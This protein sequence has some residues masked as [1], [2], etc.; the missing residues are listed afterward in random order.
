[1]G[2]PA[3]AQAWHEEMHQHA[4]DAA[5]EAIKDYQQSLV[6]DQ[7]KKT[8]SL[9][10]EYRSIDGG[11]GIIELIPRYTGSVRVHTILVVCGTGTTVTI[12]LGDETMVFPTQ[13]SGYIFLE[14]L[15]IVLSR[16]D[17]R[18]VTL[19]TPGNPLFFGV[20]GEQVGDALAVS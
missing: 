3:P 12:K 19:G 8:R 10:R 6:D 4:I 5:K 14:G 20:W 18:R 16:S 17:V 9:V 11:T 1:M 13:T 2:K 15:D 7:L